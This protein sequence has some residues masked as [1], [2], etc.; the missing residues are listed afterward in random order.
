WEKASE[1]C[2]KLTQLDREAR[3]LPE[4]WEYRLP[5]ESEWEYACRAGSAAPRHGPLEEVAWYS[6]NADQKPH[7]VGLKKANAW[8]FQDMLGNVAEWCQDWF[9]VA[10]SARSAR[11]GCY[12]NSARFC[13]SGH[14]WGWGSYA[15]RYFG[16]R[17]LAAP[18]GPFDLSPPLDD[19]P[20][21][22]EPP[23]I[24]DAIDADDFELALRLVAADPAAVDPVDFVPPPLQC[25]IYEDKPEWVEWLLDHG[26]DIEHREQDY[27]STPLVAAIVHRRPR[28][29]RTLIE[30]GA[31][32]SRAVVAAQRGL[33]GDYEDDPTLDRESYREIVALLRELGIGSRP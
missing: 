20:R 14:R 13:R 25:C 2:R 31:D 21:R 22:Q 6:A 27:G 15:G 32:A 23:S 18:G 26:A 10:R 1:Y 8:G 24:Y 30:R 9:C 3:L 7:P 4:G 29:I 28:I 19:F 16:F 33:A 11:G 17:L 12:F 5:T